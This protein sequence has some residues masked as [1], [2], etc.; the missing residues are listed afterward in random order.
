MC[1]DCFRQREHRL[2]VDLEPSV[3]DEAGQSLKPRAVGIDEEG[4]GAYA[5]FTGA[6]LRP[7]SPGAL[8]ADQD[9]AGTQAFQRLESGLSAEHLDDDVHVAHRGGHLRRGVVDHLVRAQSADEGVLGSAGGADHMSPDGLGDLDSQV[10]DASGHA[11]H[12]HSLSRFEIGDLRDI[13][14]AVSPAGG[15]AAA[16]VKLKLSGMRA[17]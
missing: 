14:Q 13:C 1:L 6:L 10:P 7:R 3:G 2:D 8:P 16:S 9:T 15:S 17:K 11:R 4:H 12:E 5:E